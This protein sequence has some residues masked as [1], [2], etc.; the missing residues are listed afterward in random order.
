M[1]WCMSPQAAARRAAMDDVALS[2]EIEAVF[3]STLG[4][5]RS[6]EGRARFNLMT[7]SAMRVCA[8]RLVLVGNA[9]N[10]LHPVAG[11]GFNLGMRDSAVLAE[12]ISTALHH[13]ADI[14]F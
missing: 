11:Q 2:R 6:V 4:S 10:Q 1:V 9:A 13:K 7:S 12:V 3:G 14:G 5:V 8:E